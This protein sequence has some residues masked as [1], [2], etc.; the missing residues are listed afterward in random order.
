MPNELI[1]PKSI[2]SGKTPE[3]RDV[4][5]WYFKLDKYNNTLTER[6]NYLKTH[7]NWRR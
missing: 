7:S 2:S 5:N 6:V 3:L 1:D 4:T